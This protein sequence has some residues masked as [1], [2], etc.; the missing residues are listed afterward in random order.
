MRLVF[1]PAYSPDLNQIEEAFSA[2]KAWIRRN[3]DFVTGELRGGQYCDPYKM[4]WDAIFN[5][6]SDKALGWFR[7]WVYCM[8]HN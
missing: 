1:L 5:V 4:L 8:K 2:I 7:Q 3:Q 6:T